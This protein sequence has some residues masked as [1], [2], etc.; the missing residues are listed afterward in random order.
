MAARH[1]R[2]TLSPPGGDFIGRRRLDTHLDGLA[3]LGITVSGNA[4]YAF[5]CRRLRAARLVLDEASVTA[6][7][8]S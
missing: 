4:P 6:T 1:G 2:V 8:T 7:E 3:Q 5:S